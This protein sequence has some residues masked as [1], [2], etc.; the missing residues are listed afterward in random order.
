MPDSSNHS[1]YLV[2][3]FVFSCP[4]GNKLLDCSIR[5]RSLSPGITNDLNVSIATSLHQRLPFSNLVLKPLS[6]SRDMDTYIAVY[7]YMYIYVH[8]YLKKC[9]VQKKSEATNIEFESAN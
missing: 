4:V 9:I 1:L 3:M 5:F 7:I 2:K 8:I 6:R